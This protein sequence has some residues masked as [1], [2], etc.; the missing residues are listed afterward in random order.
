MNLKIK[1]L[2]KYKSINLTLKIIYIYT[3]KDIIILILLKKTNTTNILFAKSARTTVW[4]PL[5][6]FYFETVGEIGFFYLCRRN[7]ANFRS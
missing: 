2:K 1:K 4:Y 7:F 3:K 6:D 5:T